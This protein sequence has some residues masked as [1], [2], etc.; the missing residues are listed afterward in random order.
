[1][2]NDLLETLEK[3][4]F[5]VYAY[6]D[7]LAIVGEQRKRLEQAIEIVEKW[8]KDN[9]MKINKKKSGV[10]MFKKK[11]SNKRNRMEEEEIE[12]YPR[13]KQYKYLGI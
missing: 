3:E 6:A 11:I 4:G 12:G 10:I 5:K 2:F 8:T 13:V 9:L 7:D 1:M